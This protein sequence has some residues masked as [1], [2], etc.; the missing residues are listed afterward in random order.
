MT[1]P[2]PNPPRVT[3]LVVT[4]NRL[5][6]LKKTV[7]R[8]LDS[9]NLAHVLVVDNASSDG[10]AEW[11]RTHGDER[12]EVLSLPRNVGGAGGFEAGMRHVHDAGTA[13]WVL[14][15]DDDARPYPGAIATFL[16]RPRNS[17]G[18]WVAAVYQP[19]GTVCEMNR[20]LINPF[21]S[22]GGFLRSL[23]AGRDGYHIQDEGYAATE[24]RDVDGGSF[25]GL[26]VSR[27]AIERTGFPDGSLFIYGDDAL[28]SLAM[29]E[30]GVRIAF[31]PG[32]KFEHAVG[33]EMGQHPIRPLWKVYYMYRNQLMVYRAAAGPVLFWP[34][35]LIKTLGW[36][37]RAQ[38]YGA[39][40]ETYRSLVR[41]AVRDGIARRTDASFDEVRS[42]ATE[43]PRS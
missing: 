39:A 38:R 5:A 33:S 20:P 28:Y 1:A 14:L 24:P 34:V 15:M 9:A 6:E 23:V 30:A 11:L 31:D 16:D 25:V 3:A 19:D 41:R 29:C 37:R 10:T 36:K 32:L 22:L 4:F 17:H 2:E 27:T 8:L 35:C 42:W 40:R 21:A 7:A 18:A 13:D 12:L 43:P 26:F